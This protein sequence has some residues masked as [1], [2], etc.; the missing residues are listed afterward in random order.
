MQQFAKAV[1]RRDLAVARGKSGILAPPQPTSTST[2]DNAITEKPSQ[3]E[4][5]PIKPEPLAAATEQSAPP[6]PE[7]TQE[8]KPSP[9]PSPKKRSSPSLEDGTNSEP[10]AKKQAVGDDK[11]PD[12]NEPASTEPKLNLDTTSAGQTN[13]QQSTDEKAPDTATFSNT[14]DL[15]SLFNDPAS[16]GGADGSTGDGPDFSTSADLN[17]EFDFD[18]FS[19][20]LTAD[21]SNDNDN[22]SALL[23]GLQDY[24]NDNAGNDADFSSLFTTDAT[25]NPGSQMQNTGTGTDGDQ[26]NNA[27]QRDTTFD[28]FLDL[29]FDMSGNENQS[30]GNDFNFDFS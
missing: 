1:M 19:A 24:A 6:Q 22:I 29:T 13:A 8:K 25:A 11:K 30:G 7:P 2:S 12:T 14:E 21:A 9:T 23:P 17:A 4:G 28:D 18:S 15:D 10:A 3:K 16:A 5:Q 27:G 20:G 26:Q